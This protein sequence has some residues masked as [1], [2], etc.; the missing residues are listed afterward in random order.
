MEDNSNFKV[1]LLINL[2]KIVIRVKNDFQNKIIYENEKIFNDKVSILD[3]NEVQIFL[4]DQIFLIEKILKNF[5]N[6]IYLIY[7][8]QFKNKRFN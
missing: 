3:N 4:D 1:F 7:S 6:R 8:Q 2:N 5:I